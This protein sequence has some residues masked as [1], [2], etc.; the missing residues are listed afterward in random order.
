MITRTAIVV[1]ALGACLVGG[2]GGN[3][4]PKVLPGVR[5]EKRADAAAKRF[6]DRYATSEGRVQRID[7]GGDTVGEGQAYGMLIAAASGDSGRFDAI[8]KWT[9]DNLRRKDGLISFLWKDG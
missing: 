2:C 6:L 3:D 7:Q 9:K 4:E 8:W 1:L 5:P